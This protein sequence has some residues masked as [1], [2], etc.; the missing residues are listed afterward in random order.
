NFQPKLAARSLAGTKAYSIAFRF[1]TANA[2]Y[3]IDMQNG[4]FDACK[5][6]G[7]ELLIHPCD[8]KEALFFDEFSNMII[9]TRIAGFLLR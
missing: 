8:S 5:K 4:I 3:S 1:A 2:Y 6:Q 7:F 9:R